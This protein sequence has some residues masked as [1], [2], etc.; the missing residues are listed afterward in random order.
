MQTASGIASKSKQISG[1]PS[2]NTLADLGRQFGSMSEKVQDYEIL[3]RE[4]MGRVGEGDIDLIRR[5]LEKVRS[6]Q[7][8]VPLLTDERS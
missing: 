5:A 1:R 7:C 4:L 2:C 8:L 6:E 3:L